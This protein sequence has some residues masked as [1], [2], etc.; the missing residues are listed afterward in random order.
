MQQKM[1]L[2]RFVP[3]ELILYS[4]HHGPEYLPC[5][6]HPRFPIA[7]KGAWRIFTVFELEDVFYMQHLMAMFDHHSFSG[8]WFPILLP[9]EKGMVLSTCSTTVSWTT[10]CELLKLPAKIIG[11]QLCHSILRHIHQHISS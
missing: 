9:A 8:S 7:L 5:R 10:I 11:S 6:C 3:S 2:P 1:L 4:H